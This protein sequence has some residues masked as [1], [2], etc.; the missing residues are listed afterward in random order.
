VT[1][2]PKK[3]QEHFVNRKQLS[4]RA[5]DEQQRRWLLI[6]VAAVFALVM[7]VVW[8]GL[9]QELVAKPSQ[10]VARVH[11]ESIS[12]ANYLERVAL[13]RFLLESQLNVLEAQQRSNPDA[14]IAQMIPYVEYQ[15]TNVATLVCDELIDEE[16]TRQEAQ[17]AGLSM[18]SDE[19]TVAIEE[20]WGYFRNPLSSPTPLPRADEPQPPKTLDEFQKQYGVFI[21]GLEASAGVGEDVYRRMV[22]ASLLRNKGM[23]WITGDIPTTEE[24]IHAK[25]ILVDTKDEAQEVLGRLQA[26]ETFTDVAKEASQD[27]GS[28]DQGGDLGWF[29]RGRMVPAFEEAAFALQPGEVS[30]PIS[31]TFGYHVIQVEERDPNREISPAILAQR[32]ASAFED[33][34]SERRTADEVERLYSDEELDALVTAQD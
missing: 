34:L 9:Y 20:G 19:V 8:V 10:P 26:G 24:Q 23:E 3:K 18:S 22:E 17:R 5:K 7:V 33:W 28:K 14:Q 4:R 6:S 2:Q 21:S 27:P 31:S 13:Q 32:K 25:H 16:I 11:G 1:K 29:G 12:L 30:E 15:L